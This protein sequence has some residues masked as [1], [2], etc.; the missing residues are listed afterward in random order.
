MKKKRFWLESAKGTKHS[1]WRKK[2]DKNRQWHG[3][4]QLWKRSMV[5]AIII[6]V[7][8]SWGAFASTKPRCISSK[9]R[10]KRIHPNEEKTTASA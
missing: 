6:T 8:S 4:F 5:N 2:S 9:I 7:S 1:K 10:K 3:S